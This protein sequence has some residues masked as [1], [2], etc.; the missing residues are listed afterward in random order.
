MG[1]CNLHVEDDVSSF[2]CDFTRIVV[3]ARHHEFGA[4]LANLL[5]NAVVTAIQQFSGVAA[6]LGVVAASLNHPEEFRAGIRRRWRGV[7]SSIAAVVVIL[8][9]AAA[10]TGVAGNITGLFNRQQQHVG[11]AVVANRTNR[12]GVPTGGTFV[13]ELLT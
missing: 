9:E 8:K 4:F 5:E 11:I 1:Q 7:R 6:W 3:L 12:L 2:T 13:P 10:R